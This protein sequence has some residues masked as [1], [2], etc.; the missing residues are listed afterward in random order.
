MVHAE[1]YAYQT[2]M[3]LA[4]TRN[5]LIT[6]TVS[7]AV[8]GLL[9]RIDAAVS[10]GDFPAQVQA[11]GQT[12][13]AALVDP[14]GLFG[15]H[16]A[17][18]RFIKQPPKVPDPLAID[19]AATFMNLQYREIRT[20]APMVVYRSFSLSANLRGRFLSSQ[21]FATATQAVRRQAL[22]QTW[23]NTNAATFVADVTIPANYVVYVGK[24]AAIYQGIYA[25]ERVPSL[26]PGGA[27]QVVVRW[28]RDP[29]LLYS[30]L[31]ATG[32]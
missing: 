9:T 4:S 13:S 2:V 23:Y 25:R 21:L 19:D 18:G 32:T 28:S 12:F 31:R 20:T 24:V 30:N 1:S 27:T 7:Q 11:A 8:A 29:A 5:P 15:S 17:I 26:Y 16:G 3:R 22:D 14:S 10:S 6:R